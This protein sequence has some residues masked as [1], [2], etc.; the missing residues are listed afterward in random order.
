MGRNAGE[1]FNQGFIMTEEKAFNPR[2]YSE[3]MDIA[4]D[5][6]L[7]PRLFIVSLQHRG[8]IPKLPTTS[9]PDEEAV[10]CIAGDCY[11]YATKYVLYN[12]SY[13]AFDGVINFA[14]APICD[15]HNQSEL[16]MEN[17]SRWTRNN[18]KLNP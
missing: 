2:G 15:N 17:V 3:H 12:G 18:V 8:V 10:L 5:Y 4:L 7:N 14:I 16:S 9:V 11:D 13:E 1:N 6:D